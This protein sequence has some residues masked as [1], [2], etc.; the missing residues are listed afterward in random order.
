MRKLYIGVLTGLVAVLYSHATHAQV[1]PAGFAQ[2]RIAGP[3]KLQTGVALAPDGRIFVAE[4]SGNV[5]IIKNNTLL[6][7][8]F[9]TIPVDSRG[10]RGLVG[11]AVDP[12]FM[13]NKYIY[14][15]Y[16]SN[17]APIRNRIS[18]FTATTDVTTFASET[19]ILNL[20]TLSS[21]LIHNGGALHFGPDGKLYVA[22][23]ENADTFSSQNL[24]SYKG[25]LLRINK[26]GSV[27]SGNPF[28]TGS[29]QRRRVWAY[30]LRNPFTF[31]IDHETG[32]IFVN[33]VGQ[34]LWEEINDAT[35][36]GR[37]FGWPMTEG[38]FNQTSF[39]ALTNPVYAYPHGTGADGVGCAIVGGTF[40]SPSNTNYPAAYRGKYFFQENCEDWINMLDLSNGTVVRSPFITSMIQNSLGLTMG[41][42]G[43]IYFLARHG[44]SLYK[45]VYNNTSVPTITNH[46]ASSTVA[47]GQP[48]SFSVGAL[49]T[50]PLSYQWQ[51]N[52][53][54]I[55]G[56]TDSTYTIAQTT[57]NDAG[58]YRVIVSN[59]SGNVTS[60]SAD[61]SVV[62][63]AMPVAEILTPV[64]G[65]TWVAGDTISFSG[66][67]TDPDQG[68]LLPQ[69]MSWAINFHHN[70][71]HHDQ[72]PLAG[73][74][75]GTFTIP[76]EGET[77]DNVW[78]RIILTVTDTLGFKAKDSVDIYPLKSTLSFATDPPGLQITLDGQPFNTPGSVVGVEGV[79]R[80]LGVIS[81]QTVNGQNY[82]FAS[83]SNGGNQTQTITTPTADASYIANFVLTQRTFYRALNLN[84]PPLTIDGNNWEASAEAAN[85]SFVGSTYTNQSVSLIPATDENRATMLRSC[86][87]RNPSVAISG[88]PAGN[89]EV[90]VYVWEDN[91]SVTYSL[92]LEGTVV[93]NNYNSG[94]AGT[95][96]KLGPFAAAISD[97]TINIAANGIDATLS[98][99]EIWSR[100]QAAQP[101]PTF[102]TD[103][104]AAEAPPDG[105]QLSVYPN[106]FSDKVIVAFTTG[107]SGPTSV[108]M[109]D[110]RGIKV[111]SIFDRSVEKGYEDEIELDIP[112]LRDGVYILEMINGSE[113]KRLKMMAVK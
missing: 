34:G 3:L 112:D 70:T 96:E 47:T 48:A 36:G 4:Q 76:L 90:W 85:F 18:R 24:D 5:R 29:E 16:T 92:S 77:S 107:Q 69:S 62:N 27:P 40:I 72:P 106:P 102:P 2:S 32:K 26:D 66:Q 81:P 55:P 98:G 65:L 100:T 21:A 54:N 49:G 73:I 51:K 15:Y 88:V 71:H 78:Y 8:P 42:D 87:W 56:A 1:F 83:W 63:N 97:D 37:N 13:T 14:V 74:A 68:D 95:W 67:G 94:P 59:A 108:S 20:E 80:T 82:E 41:I 111:S 43:L 35:V 12:D 23:G 104:T 110:L 103:I 58:S 10:E 25:K 45:I 22:V 60:N 61:L 113:R 44:E 38:A 86:I 7:T 46:P 9:V 31:S 57:P 89:Y 109:Y 53:I 11:I 93:Q 19:V 75:S 64:A 30:G 105:L 17:V 28:P 99:V 101:T 52:Q 39:P 50:P 6:T 79:Q 33:D 84:G 91:F